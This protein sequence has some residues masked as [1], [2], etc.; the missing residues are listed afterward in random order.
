MFVPLH[1]YSHYSFLR[2]TAS[3]A[4]L[5][6]TASR[7]GYPA[8][9]L[10][11]RDGV[12]GAVEFDRACRET[13]IR[14]L[15][16]VEL[17]SPAGNLVLLARNRE[18]WSELCRLTTARR[19][20]PGFSPARVFETG[21]RGNLFI[22]VD[23]PALLPPSARAIPGLRLAWN[24]VRARQRGKGEPV[25]VAMP[26]VAFPDPAA[27]AVAG[28]LSLIRTRKEI[29]SSEITPARL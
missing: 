20:D 23:N 3:P 28:F 24:P 22:L 18:G 6:R 16:G 14:P 25:A 29:P 8:L 26:R 9:A 10:T 19:L 1:C 21:R 13:G 2:G 12:Y 15:L 17:T 4:V 11:D 5:A 7:L 27:A